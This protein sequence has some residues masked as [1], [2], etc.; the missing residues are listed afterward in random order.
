MKKLTSF[1][2]ILNIIL[3]CKSQ[4]LQGGIDELFAIGIFNLDRRN[5]EDI[6]S[7]PYPHAAFGSVMWKIRNT[8]MKPTMRA[9][10]YFEL[11]CLGYKR[12]RVTPD[13]KTL[14]GYISD[15]LERAKKFNGGSEIGLPGIS[16]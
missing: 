5:L 14:E 1:I 8:R 12:L 15:A 10:A 3:F 9:R 6:G 16:E 13:D 11:A 7:S 2:I 4:D